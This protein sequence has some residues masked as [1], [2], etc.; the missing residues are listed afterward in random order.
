MGVDEQFESLVQLIN[1][2]KPIKLVCSKYKQIYA[3]YFFNGLLISFREL[4][5][6]VGNTALTFYK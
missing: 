6:V 4:P 2:S 3:A 5:L 1:T